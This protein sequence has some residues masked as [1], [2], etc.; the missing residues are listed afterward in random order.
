MPVLKTTTLDQLTLTNVFLTP[1]NSSN[2]AS[3]DLSYTNF[4]PGG[5]SDDKQWFGG[6]PVKYSF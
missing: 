6:A 4:V 3:G 5:G 2:A 1:S